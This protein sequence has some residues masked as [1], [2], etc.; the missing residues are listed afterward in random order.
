MKH[1]EF[2]WKSSEGLLGHINN[3][4]ETHVQVKLNHLPNKEELQNIFETTTI[5][6][7]IPGTWFLVGIWR[8]IPKM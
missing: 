4:F 1:G 2:G 8:S 5:P 7:P 3:S 6:L